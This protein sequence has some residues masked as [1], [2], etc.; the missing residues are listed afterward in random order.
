MFKLDACDL[1]K[2]RPNGALTVTMSLR[3]AK[4]LERATD[5]SKPGGKIDCGS[6]AKIGWE[7]K[8]PG[9]DFSLG[10]NLEEALHESYLSA[11]VAFPDSFN[12]SLPNH[13]HNLV[14]S[15]G[16]PRRDETE[17]AESVFNVNYISHCIASASSLLTGWWL[18]HKIVTGISL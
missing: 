5:I 9:P 15:D 12:L 6:V 8:K 14:P 7:H 13:V 2:V 4:A 11:N 17:E 18:P 16:P 3:L 10:G 1:Q